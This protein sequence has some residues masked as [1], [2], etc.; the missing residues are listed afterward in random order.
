VIVPRYRRVTLDGDNPT[1]Q[2]AEPVLHAAT[3]LELGG[4]RFD[5]RFRRREIG[6]RLDAV[7]V[8][9]PELFDR[10][11]LYGDADGDYPDNAIRFALFC[12]AALEYLRLRGERPSV[13]HAHDWQAGLVPAYQKMLFSPDPIVGGVPVVFT[14]HNLAFQGVFPVET[15]DSIGLPRDV[16]HL[17][18]ME[19][20]GRISYLKAGMNFS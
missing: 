15:L 8:D 20:F 1:P 5:V 11:G 17:E 13:I 18:A 9:V 12:R 2:G 19:F 6:E 10:D 14:I 4:R 3:T 7:F 16:L